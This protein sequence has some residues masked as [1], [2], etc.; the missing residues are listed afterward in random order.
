[1]ILQISKTYVKY[2]QEL[3]DCSHFTPPDARV[4]M[5]M[6]E[7]NIP[8]EMEPTPLK[9]PPPKPPELINKVEIVDNASS[10]PAEAAPKGMTVA[11][12]AAIYHSENV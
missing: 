11:E 12:L 5:V 2:L 4:F 7:K 1:M 3:G 9:E 10:Q 8:T 6:V